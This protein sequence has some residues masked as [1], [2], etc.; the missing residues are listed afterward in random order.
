[1]AHTG[2][3][4]CMTLD[5]P[6]DPAVAQSLSTKKGIW[7]SPGG[8]IDFILVAN[9]TDR[10]WLP[11]RAYVEGA[12]TVLRQCLVMR[13][14]LEMAWTGE[15]WVQIPDLSLRKCVVLENLFWIFFKLTFYLPNK[16]QAFFL[17]MDGDFNETI[18]KSLSTQS[19]AHGK[20][21][22]KAH[23]IWNLSTIGIQWQTRKNL[24]I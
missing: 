9:F 14:S 16:S 2:Q 18:W 17:R 4:A 5:K 20:C 11:R 19:Q 23:W 24:V 7:L 15:A 3:T 6:C 8:Q 13:R 1:M 21:S 22:I 12:Q 10:K